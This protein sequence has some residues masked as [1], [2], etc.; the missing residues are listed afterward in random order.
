VPRSPELLIFSTL[1]PI[2]FVLLFRYVF[3]GAID[4][5]GYSS[6][7]QYLI[8]GIFAQTVVFGSSFTAVGL[9]DDLSKGFID[10]LRSLP[11]SQGA[12]LVG[13]TLSDLTRNVFTFFVMLIV[14]FLVGFRFEGGILPAIAA[15]FLMLAFSY[16]FSWIQAWIG[17]SVKSVEAA[18]SAGFIWMFPL[19]FVSSAFVPT[20]TMP[21]A[22]EWFAERNPFTIVTNAARAMYSGNPVGNDAWVALA[23]AVGITVVFATISIRTFTRAASR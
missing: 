15:T 3:G 6:Y 22:M 18:N 17:L 20:D 23:W 5:P 21:A 19:T 16:S 11:I 10:R 2:M 14:A 1:Q 9:A 8:P 7:A 13:R 4:T 12:V